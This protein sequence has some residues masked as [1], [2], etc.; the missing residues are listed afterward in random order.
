MKRRTTIHPVQKAKCRHET[1][2]E[3]TATVKDGSFHNICK[4]HFA[5]ELPVILYML[6]LNKITKGM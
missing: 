3:S 5:N 4:C 1:S 6:V 2:N